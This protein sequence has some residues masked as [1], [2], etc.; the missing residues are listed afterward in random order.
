MVV[1]FALFVNLK[2]VAL[3]P[4]SAGAV[5]YVLCFLDPASERAPDRF[6]SVRKCVH[7]VLCFMFY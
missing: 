1:G 5:L 7:N 2:F 6:V 4:N 3:G